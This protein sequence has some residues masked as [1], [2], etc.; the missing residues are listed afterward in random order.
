MKVC[1]LLSSNRTLVH[2]DYIIV[3]TK[4]KR[5]FLLI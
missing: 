2:G 4:A 5:V 1:L 3:L